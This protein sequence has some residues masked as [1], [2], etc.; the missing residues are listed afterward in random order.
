MGQ[1]IRMDRA[2]TGGKFCVW[3]EPSA[4]EEFRLPRDYDSVAEASAAGER[5]LRADRGRNRMNRLLVYADDGTH[6]YLWVR[7]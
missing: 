3:V 4:G 7:R 2:A 6:R 5:L 1:P